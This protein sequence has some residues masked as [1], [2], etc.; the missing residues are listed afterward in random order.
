MSSSQQG[1]THAPAGFTLWFTGLPCSGKTTLSNLVQKELRQLGL[2]VEQLDG[3]VV[4]KKLCGDLGFSKKDRE[5]NIDRI[6]YIASLLTKNGVATLVS[7]V[8]PY[9]SM[10]QNARKQIRPFVEIY[11][12]CPLSVCEG[13]D[14]KNMYHLAR[15]GKI[16][17]FTGV[18]DPY[19]EPSNPEL[20]LDTNI[21]SVENCAEKVLAYLKQKKLIV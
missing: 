9:E 5:S 2:K 10:R 11:L 7:L 12:R 16:L 4:R 3:D 8:S 14:I 18:S 17:N 19:E 6:A 21:L 15:E 1:F 20:I 13:R